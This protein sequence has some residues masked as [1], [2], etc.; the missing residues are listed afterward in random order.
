[1]TKLPKSHLFLALLLFDHR[2]VDAFRRSHLEEWLGCKT[3]SL[4]PEREIIVLKPE[5]I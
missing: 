3:P 5:I 1:M 2:V 4:Q